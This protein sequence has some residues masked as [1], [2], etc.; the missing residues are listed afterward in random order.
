[1]LLLQMWFLYLERT[2]TTPSFSCYCTNRQTIF[3]NIAGVIGLDYLREIELPLISEG[4]G[5]RTENGCNQES[6]GKL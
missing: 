5:E 2:N 3:Y 4:R 6:S 1:M